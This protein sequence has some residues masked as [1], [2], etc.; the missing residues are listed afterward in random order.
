M[1]SSIVQVTAGVSRITLHK[2]S[3]DE[4]ITAHLNRECNALDQLLHSTKH[5]VKEN[6]NTESKTT[7]R[8]NLRSR[9][10]R[11]LQ[12][13]DG[14]SD[15][16]SDNESS[17]TSSESIV[18]KDYENAQYFGVVEI[19]TPSQSFQVIYDTGSSDLWVPRVGCSHCGIPFGPTKSKY[20]DTQSSSYEV[21]GEDFEIIYGSGS[22]SGFFSKDSVTLAEDIV[23]EGQEFGQVSDA[24]GLGLLYSLGKFDGILG[25]GFSSLS[26]GLKTTVFENALRQNKVD[27]PIFAFSLGQE[28]GRPGELTF[29]G[30]D[31]SK[32]EGDLE[33]VKLNAS[34]YWQ[35]TMDSIKAGKYEKIAS[36]DEITAIVDSGTSFI[37][38]P[39]YEVD[40]LAKAAGAKANIM[41]E[42]TV[43]CD[44]I[45][46]IPDIIFTIGGAEYTIPGSKTVI[47]A[48]GTCLFTFLPTYVPPPGPQWILGDIFMREYYTVFNYHDKSIG[49]AKAVT[50]DN[51][52]E[53]NLDSKA[54]LFGEQVLGNN[55]DEHGCLLS[56][57]YFWCESSNECNRPWE[58]AC[59]EK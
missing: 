44:K 28:D 34:T 31:S 58:V 13:S 24:G 51:N 38:G 19:G 47:E 4:L 15:N 11:V 29:G 2:R 57:G 23:V 39:R 56:A 26:V 30:Y 20:D 49:F 59:G 25:L 53:G 6:V 27:Q 17:S 1:A 7:S 40:K 45:D 18:V 33:Y 5:E 35:I 42:Y 46:D 54:V 21:D 14:D 16:E 12:N 3:N 37:T 50:D 10:K 8:S 48:Q 41:G 22:V 55:R 52:E 32:F 43:D 36:G 9:K